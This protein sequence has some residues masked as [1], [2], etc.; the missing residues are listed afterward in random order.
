MENG[1]SGKSEEC[2]ESGESDERDED[3]VEEGESRFEG[4][5]REG[6]MELRRRNGE[7]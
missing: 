5:V 3:G 7:G 4:F 1:R 6:D 2:E